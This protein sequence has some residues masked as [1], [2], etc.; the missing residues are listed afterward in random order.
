MS[1]RVR[2]TLAVAVLTF[3]VLAFVAVAAPGVVRV[4]LESDLV[5]AEAEAAFSNIEF[6][7]GIVG[8]VPDLLGEVFDPALIDGFLEQIF[9]DEIGFDEEGDLVLGSDRATTLGDVV[10]LDELRDDGAREQIEVLMSVGRFDD[11]VDAAGG[12]F[13]LQMRDGSWSIIAPDGSFVIVDE[14]FRSLEVPLVAGSEIDDLIFFDLISVTDEP[15][16]LFDDVD[17]DA[18]V[19]VESAR[20]DGTEVIVAVDAGSADRSVE[21]VRSALWIAVPILTLVVAAIA[22]FLADRAL[23]P[24]RSIT[25]QAATISGG[26]LDTRV[27]VPATGDE[28]ATLATTVNEMLDR[29]ERDDGRRRRFVSDASH[30]L[31]SPVAVMRSEAEVAL[32][33]PD[34]VAVEDLAGSVAAESTRMASVIDDLLALARHDEGLPPPTTAVDL[35]D[36]VLD[37]ARRTRRVPVEVAQVSAGR[38]RGR[39]DELARLTGHLLDNAARHANSRVAVGLRTTPHAVVLTVDDDGPGVPID[40]RDR[41]FE[42]FTRLDEARSRDRGGAGLGLAVVVGIAERSGGSVRVTD[43][44]FGGARFEVSFPTAG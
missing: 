43:S 33:H 42:R 32:R 21:R 17:D 10:V 12:S 25:D 5:E 35:D 41:I 29:L 28:V 15:N 18:S 24:V 36:V 34:A 2:L 13:A 3:A 19:I 4:E 38:I 27:P 9:G 39:A 11:F 20:V 7:D 14:D 1:V 31:R 16:G 30:E 22:W 8:D 6:T 44:S 37:E 40:A 23:R 26:N